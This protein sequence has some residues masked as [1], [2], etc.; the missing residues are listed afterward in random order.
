M[1][2]IMTTLVVLVGGVATFAP[3]VNAQQ[4]QRVQADRPAPQVR[5]VA[6]NLNNPSGVAIQAETN[7]IFVSERRGV[8]R[9]FRKEE[10]GRGRRMEING[11]PTDIYGKGPMYDIGPLGLA[12]LDYHLVVGGGSRPDGEELVHIFDI[13]E[14]PAESPQK[15][16]DAEYT[17]GPIPMGEETGKGEGNFYGVAVTRP[18]Q[19]S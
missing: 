6:R 7:H 15:E 5:V 17:L 16:S 1:I 4:T 8:V 13:E 11:F 19:S 14:T 9:F 10:G 18:A 2:R 12:W 3:L